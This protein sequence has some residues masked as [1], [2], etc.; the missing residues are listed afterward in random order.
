MFSPMLFRL[1]ILY[2]RLTSLPAFQAFRGSI[3]CA[4]EK[5]AEPWVAAEHV[6]NGLSIQDARLEVV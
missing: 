1:G 5:P 4:F 3:I 2:E 6:Q